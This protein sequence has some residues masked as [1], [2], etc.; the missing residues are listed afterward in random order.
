[1]DLNDLQALMGE[2]IDAEDYRD[3]WVIDL[4]PPP[5][6]GASTD[7]GGAGGGGLI[8]E[9]RRLADSLGAYVH[10]V[11]NGDSDEAIAFGADRVHPLALHS[12]D[13][14]VSA[15]AALFE[16]HKPE[17]VFMPATPLGDEVAGRL[18][19]RLGGGVVQDC[20]ALRLD[21][22]TRELVG[23]HPVYDGAYYLDTAITKKPAIVTVRPGALAAPYRDSGR[24]GEI[25][26]LE[27]APTENRVRAL[28]EANY[29]KEAVPLRKASKVVA[30]GRWGNDE[31][32]IQIAKQIAEK[33]G[34][35]FAGDRSAFDSGWIAR[36]QIVGVVGT[37]IAPDVYIAAGIWGDTLHRAGVEGAKHV[38]AIHPKPDAPIFKYADVCIV[39]QPKDVLPILLALL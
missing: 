17:F 27:A 33:I 38:I 15:L 13:E 10:Y 1:M 26:P 21:E 3:L 31:G 23:V 37:E 24:T 12:G 7:R 19:Y 22:S 4:N 39:G 9:A 35:H 36:E 34:A 18:A 2:S 20:V 30:V 25:E 6:A 14:I 28:G 8:G 11:G 5:L 16:T 32:S 29:A